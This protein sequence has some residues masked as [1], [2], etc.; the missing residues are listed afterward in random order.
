MT[1]HV[2]AIPTGILI[3]CMEDIENMNYYII[4]FTDVDGTSFNS[5]HECEDRE[6]AL[7][8]IRDNINSK[9]YLVRGVISESHEVVE[10]V[11]APVRRSSEPVI[12]YDV[13]VPED[14]PVYYALKWRLGL[15]M[16]TRCITKAQYEQEL[17][18]HIRNNLKHGLV[19][20]R[21]AGNKAAQAYNQ[22]LNASQGRGTYDSRDYYIHGGTRENW[23]ESFAT[24]KPQ[25]LVWA[26]D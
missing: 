11:S 13:D 17:K 18:Y 20:R 19:T 16:R 12:L 9:P 5:R 10:P 25:P 26:E 15:L 2:G 1:R 24:K 23:I 4:R 3:M 8:W 7:E 21:H 22:F 6:E 14:M